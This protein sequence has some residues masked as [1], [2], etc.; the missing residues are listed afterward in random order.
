MPNQISQIVS[1]LGKKITRDCH[2]RGVEVLHLIGILKGA[3]NLLPNLA[4]AIDIPCTYD[5]MSLS[6]YGKGQT[7]SGNVKI[8]C[9][10]RDDIAG[11]DVIVVED[12]A[13]TRYTLKILLE[14]LGLRSPNSLEVCCLL[15]K[16][17]RKENQV[18]IKYIGATIPNV[19]VVGYGLDGGSPE[20]PDS[21]IYRDLPL[22]AELKQ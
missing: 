12:I 16:P 20:F 3:A 19:F 21:Q 9:D 8:G 5:F 13:D 15:D 2:E 1:G 22:I 4:Y 17:E 18:D 10:L 14:I 11:K 7:S 6:S